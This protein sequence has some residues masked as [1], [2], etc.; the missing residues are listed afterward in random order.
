METDTRLEAG[1][2]IPALCIIE[3]TGHGIRGGDAKKYN[4]T[5]VSVRSRSVSLGILELE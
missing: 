2:S 3:F 5:D 4:D 1:S